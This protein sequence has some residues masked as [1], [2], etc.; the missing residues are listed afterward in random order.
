M[1][2][3]AARNASV[4]GETRISGA[5]SRVEVW[6]VPTNEELVVARQAAELIA[7]HSRKSA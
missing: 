5:D 7:E 1:R 6:V 3:D 4:K 2:L